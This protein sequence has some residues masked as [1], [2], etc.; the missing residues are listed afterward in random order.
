MSVVITLAIV[1]I[2]LFVAG[3]VY[4]RVARLKRAVRSTWRQLEQQRRRRHGIVERLTAAL[5]GQ[6]VDAHA[7]AAVVGARQNAATAGGPADAARKEAALGEALSALLTAS[8][9]ALSGEI[10]ALARELGDVERAYREARVGYNSTA[11]R[12]NTAISVVPGSFVTKVGN[13]PKA[14]LFE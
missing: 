14:E 13:F 5:G 6:S 8:A 7:V 9:I 3:V 2:L 11:R 1:L 12:Y 10:A 4:D